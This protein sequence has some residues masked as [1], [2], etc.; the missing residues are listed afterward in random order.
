M[1]VIDLIISS[2]DITFRFITV[3]KL[4]LC[5]GDL[6]KLRLLHIKSKAHDFHEKEKLNNIKKSND[7][8]LGKLLEISQGKHT[9]VGATKDLSA[10][11]SMKSL[12]NTKNK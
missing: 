11:L 6:K 3:L 8:L 12:H 10:A 5:V 7:L 9:F 1:S 4:N 2:V